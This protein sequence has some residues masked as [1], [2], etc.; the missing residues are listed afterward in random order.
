[1]NKMKKSKHMDKMYKTSK[2]GLYV[3]IIS[4]RIGINNFTFGKFSQLGNK[5]K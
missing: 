5:R 3:Y 1:M 4:Q 2:M